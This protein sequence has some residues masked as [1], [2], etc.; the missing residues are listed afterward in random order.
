[1]HDIIKHKECTWINDLYKRGK[2][3][4]KF[5]TGHSRVNA[6]YGTYSK[7]QLLKL[8]KTRFGSYFLTFRRLLRVRQALGAMVMS[9]EWDI[10]MAWMQQSTLSLIAIFGHRASLFYSSP[11]QFIT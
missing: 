2:K 1:M 10:E 4:N 8:A 9:D 3:L 7:L 5:I 6:F 11:S